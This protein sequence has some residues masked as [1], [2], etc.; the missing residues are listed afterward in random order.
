MNKLRKWNTILA[1]ILKDIDF[2]KYQ[3]L[4]YKKLHEYKCKLKTNECKTTK[5][6]QFK[7]ILWLFEIKNN[8]LHFS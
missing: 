4:F 8:C 2:T 7:Y 5:K 6:M 3:W 1:C